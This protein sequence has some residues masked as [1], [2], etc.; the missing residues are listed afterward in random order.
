MAHKHKSTPVL[1]ELRRTFV[2]ICMLMTSAVLIGVL[3]SSLFATWTTQRDII[4]ESLT[5][6]INDDM[7]NLPEVGF[8]RGI[9]MESG[10]ERPEDQHGRNRDNHLLALAV[11]VSSN[12]VVIKTSRSPIAINSS[13]L[14]EVVYDAL[15]AAEDTGSIPEL[16]IAWKRALFYST[17]DLDNL[18]E[19]EDLGYDPWARIAIV[20]TTAMDNA[21][22]EQLKSDAII[23]V[24]AFVALFAVSWALSSWA[25]TPVERAWDNQ[26]RFIADASHE[27]KTPLAVIVANTEILAHDEGIPEESKRWVKSTADEAA[28]MRSLVNDLLEL[29]RADEGAASG[30]MHKEDVDLSDIVDSA[31]L[32]FDAIAF[33]RNCLIET[34]IDTGIHVQGDPAWL[35]R[36]TKI[37]VDNAC[38]YAASGTTIEVKL[39]KSANRITLS[40]TNQ[41][42]VIDQADLPHLFERFYRSDKARNRETGGFGLGLAIAK[43]IAEAHGGTISAT[44]SEADGTTFMVT[45]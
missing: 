11:D 26:R 44:S 16:H 28:H 42:N 32:E 1:A 22:Q 10:G 6:A 5:R 12:G 2:I 31:A 43:G 3:G 20:D 14:S 19:Y 17:V 29:A 40:V 39:S 41:G 25:L 18:E 35:Q 9:T 34:S 27:L 33:E 38:K 13:V 23:V 15:N 37:L 4:E 24:V 36:L 8:A 45:L 30:A 21:F 7:D